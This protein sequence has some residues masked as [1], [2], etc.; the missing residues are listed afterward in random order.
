MIA[1]RIL[2]SYR[3]AVYLISVS[4]LTALINLIIL[5]HLIQELLVIGVLHLDDGSVA[6]GV[7]LGGR[8]CVFGVDN[9]IGHRL[10]AAPVLRPCGRAVLHGAWHVHVL[11]VLVYVIKSIL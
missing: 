2:G 5:E 1:R 11:Y 3:G 6:L 9:G 4:V 10:V 8:A 7:V